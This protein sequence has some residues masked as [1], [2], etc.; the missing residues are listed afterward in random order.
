MPP[1]MRELLKA[2]QDQHESEHYS[3]DCGLSPSKIYFRFILLYM[4]EGLPARMSV[5]YVHG[6]SSWRPEEYQTPWDWS[7]RWL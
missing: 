6:W 4:Y 7:Y 2:S 1:G 3:E 5:H